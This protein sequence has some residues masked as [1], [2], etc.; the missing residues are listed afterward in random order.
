MHA[1]SVISLIGYRAD[2]ERLYALGLDVI[3]AK[4]T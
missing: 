2:T 4:F 3:V 1:H